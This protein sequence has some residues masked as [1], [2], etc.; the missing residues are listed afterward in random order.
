MAPAALAYRLFEPSGTAIG[1]LQWALRGSHVL[2]WSQADAV[3]T[4]DA[5][6][7]GYRCFAFHVI[8]VAHWR[9]HLAGGL[10]PRLPALGRRHR[11]TV[12]AWDWAG[13]TTAR[14]LWLSR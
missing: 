2:P 5:R 6:A 14:D 9:Y 3:F 4:T 12:Y 10:A 11:L 1:P 7:P 13:N 8:C